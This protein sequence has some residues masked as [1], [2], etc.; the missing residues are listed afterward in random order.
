LIAWIL[1]ASRFPAA[2]GCSA[3]MG[4]KD[5]F[6]TPEAILPSLVVTN[7]IGSVPMV[8]TRVPTGMVIGFSVR[9]LN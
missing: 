4:M 6:P 7:R 5:V 9:F 2:P 1:P 3:W 8:L